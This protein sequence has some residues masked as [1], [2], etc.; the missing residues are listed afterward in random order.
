[1]K[2][3][4]AGATG[5][6]GRNTLEE[7]L[8]CGYDTTALVR[9][10]SRT[11]DAFAEGVTV[12]E[13]EVTDA[14]TLKGCCAGVDVVISCVGI[15][16]QRDGMT[17]EAVDYQANRNLLDEALAQNVR[18]FI[19]VSVYKGEVLRHTVQ[20]CAAKERFADELASS[21]IGYCVVRPNGF[22]SDMT[23]FYEMAKNGRVYLFGDGSLR[24]TP[25]HGADLAREVV[26]QIESTDVGLDIG[27]PETLTQR[28][29]ALLAFEALGKPPKITYI[30]H[31]MRKCALSL[32]RVFMSRESF[33]PTEFFLNAAAMDTA[34]PEYGKETLKDYFTELAE[35]EAKKCTEK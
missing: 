31:W 11:N 17:Y 33:G 21:G 34:C 26:K 7:L 8:R 35:K 2:V 10:Q 3:L 9:A 12:V 18:R 32:A 14:A 4:L 24:L 1:M 27:G 25:I 20:L 30:P 15:T 19:Y 13:A 29:I 5:Y 23:E 16:R 28:E 6:L 22:F